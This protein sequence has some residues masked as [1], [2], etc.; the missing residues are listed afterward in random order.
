M[1]QEHIE[2]ILPEL[3]HKLVK[4]PDT[5]VYQNH[6]HNHCEILLFVRGNADY[7]IDGQRFCPSPYDLLFIPAATYHYLI[8]TA[9]IPY[10]NYVIGITPDFMTAAQYEKL[11]SPPYMI[12]IKEDS[13]LRG[14][15]KRL[16]D[17]AERYSNE[18]FHACASAVVRE[19]ITYCAYR[20]DALHSVHS[21]SPAHIDKIVGYVS[22]HLTEPL[23]ASIIARELLLSRSYVQNLF[24]AYMHIGL[25]T[26]IMQ[27][28]IYAAHHDLENG[29]PPG[30]VAE[31]YCFGDYSGFY[32]LYK[33]T[34]SRPPRAKQ[35]QKEI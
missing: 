3:S 9:A 8:P 17:Y 35:A 29:I 20:K 32:R 6:I 16:D 21:G 13:E 12:R 15:F 1:F 11:F 2:P 10:E 33:K 7:N 34:F 27:K 24:S 23:S 22:V 19:I 4:T 18:D 26:Y 28:K 31:K 5:R 25:K 14:F 30:V